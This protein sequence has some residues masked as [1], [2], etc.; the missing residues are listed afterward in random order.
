M[1]TKEFKVIIRT[2]NNVKANVEELE[3]HINSIIENPIDLSKYVNMWLYSSEC[4]NDKFDEDLNNQYN[5]ICKR[6]ERKYVQDENAYVRFY[7][8]EDN[9]DIV[10][11]ISKN[12]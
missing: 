5:N 6:L 9:W 8:S 10:V 1:K 3:K 11:E 2:Y 12:V 7:F 4:I